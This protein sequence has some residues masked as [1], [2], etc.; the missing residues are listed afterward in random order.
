MKNF[1]LGFS[2]LL[3][4]LIVV[5]HVAA[6]HA[7]S[8]PAVTVTA[9]TSDAAAL[10]TETADPVADN[11]PI[12]TRNMLS[13]IHDG[14]ELMIP[15]IV[16]SF[17]LMVV[18][19]ERFISLGRRR[20]IPRPFVKRLLGQIE[21]GQIDREESQHLCQ[22]N[23]SPIAKVFA[24]AIG[25]WGR[26]SAEMEQAII[27]AGERVTTKLRKHLRVINGVAT[28]SPLLG[29]LGTVV[30]MIRAFNSIATSDAMGRPELLAGGI[31]QALLTTAAGLSVAIPALIFY[32]YFTSK[33]DRLVIEIDARSQE[34]VGLISAEAIE[35]NAATKSKRK[36]AA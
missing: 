32:M 4:S 34:L 25:K 19:F 13:I 8:E 6:V 3:L 36:K 10:P 26:S 7:Q 21:E 5:N 24:A 20:N 12:P 23:G 35:Q 15:L 30:G 14:G 22:E 18:V 31:S 1:R 11:T 28:V 17:V 29:L 27:D 16:C 2:I 9:E 33:V